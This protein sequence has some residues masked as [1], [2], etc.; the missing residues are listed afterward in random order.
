M[1]EHVNDDSSSWPGI[2]LNQFIENGLP[3]GQ[4]ETE[5]VVALYVSTECQNRKVADTR[6]QSHR[7]QD[8][9]ARNIEHVVGGHK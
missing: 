7:F 1:I 8:H 6:N 3:D 9:N 5:M 4:I 2:M